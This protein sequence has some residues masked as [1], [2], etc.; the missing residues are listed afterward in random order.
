MRLL[1]LKRFATDRHGIITI[2]MAF[3]S[4]FLVSLAIGLFDFG[5]LALEQSRVESAVR[6]GTQYA[7]QS[8][9]DAADTAAVINAA[10][11]DL[12]AAA[13]QYTVQADRF[14]ACSGIATPCN[15]TCTDGAYAPM[16][17]EVSVSGSVDLLFDYPGIQTPVTVSALS[18]LRIR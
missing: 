12:G 13:D 15:G 14:C 10:R 7:M 6:A 18:S 2:E 1:S 8:P 5:R 9:A 17:S 3:L 11:M 16:Y 4:V